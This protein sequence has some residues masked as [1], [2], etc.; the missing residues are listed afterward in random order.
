MG[1]STAAWSLLSPGL[2][3]VSIDSG[4]STLMVSPT[5]AQVTSGGTTSFEHRLAYFDGKTTRVMD[6]S[7][8]LEIHCVLPFVKFKDK[9]LE[10][11]P[12]K[13]NQKEQE[14]YNFDVPPN[15]ERVEFE[16]Q[17]FDCLGPNATYMVA[18]DDGDPGFVKV[19]G[20]TIYVD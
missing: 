13:G 2:D 17:N 20:K 12:K 6:Y 3:Y 15:F 19:A 4:T 7:Q 14:I 18:C 8:Q 5:L 10:K 1:E 9:D 11:R 16:I